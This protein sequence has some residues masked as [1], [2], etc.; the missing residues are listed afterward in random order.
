MDKLRE[1][2]L[3]VGLLR[4]RVFRPL[5]ADELV[6]ALQ[7]LK[8]V[9]VLDRAACPGSRGGP[10]F[11]DLKAAFYDAFSQGKVKPQTKIVSFLYGLGGREFRPDPV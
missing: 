10:L 7:H 8:V 9:G 5:P 2:G 4:L 3:L 11:T 1:E 6:N